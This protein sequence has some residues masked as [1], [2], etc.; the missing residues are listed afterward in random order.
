MHRVTARTV[1]ILEALAVDAVKAGR[2]RLTSI[3]SRT[4]ACPDSYSPWEMSL[5][6]RPLRSLP[7]VL[8]PYPD[9]RLGSWLSRTGAIYGCTVSERLSQLAQILV[10]TA[11]VGVVLFGRKARDHTLIN[12]ISAL[13]FFESMLRNAITSQEEVPRFASDAGV[14]LDPVQDE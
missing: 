9:G 6:S 10:R 3:S 5:A 2:E 8:R 14:S 13:L 1:S 12:T 4:S 7:V 11:S